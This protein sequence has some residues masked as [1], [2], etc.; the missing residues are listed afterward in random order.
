MKMESGQ[1][2]ANM[3]L[4][5][6]WSCER[7]RTQEMNTLSRPVGEVTVELSSCFKSRAVFPG[8]LPGK[9]TVQ[10]VHTDSSD[11]NSS[12]LYHVIGSSL[13]MSTHSVSSVPSIVVVSVE[14]MKTWVFKCILLG[15]LSLGTNKI[16]A[17]EGEMMIQV[18]EASTWVTLSSSLLMNRPLTPSLY[19]S[20]M[21]LVSRS[22]PLGFSHLHVLCMCFLLCSRLF[23]HSQLKHLLFSELSHDL[24]TPPSILS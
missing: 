9:N 7:H 18:K 14:Q 22:N 21:G 23:I 15:S 19:V 4:F 1:G 12:H 6:M 17:Y 8:K 13:I 3:P 24:P 5:H 11:F 2:E 20:A 16:Y 10:N